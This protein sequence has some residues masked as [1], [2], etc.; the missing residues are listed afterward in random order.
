MVA[1]FM[2]VLMVEPV[3]DTR[4]PHPNHS[5]NP[6]AQAMQDIESQLQR[7]SMGQQGGQ[8]GGSVQQG[9]PHGAVGHSHAASMSQQGGVP[10][11]GGGT[12]PVNVGSGHPY[13]RTQSS[14]GQQQMPN[15]QQMRNM[16]NA[17][18]QQQYPGRQHS[19]PMPEIGITDI[20]L[21]S[22]QQYMTQP[23]Y[24]TMG[25]GSQNIRHGQ[26]SP[27]MRA[28]T[29]QMEPWGYPAY[30]MQ[31]L[32]SRDTRPHT[33]RRSTVVGHTPR[34]Y[35]DDSDSDSDYDEFGAIRRPKPT[36]RSSLPNTY[37]P[38]MVEFPMGVRSMVGNPAMTVGAP[39]A[40]PIAAY[41][42]QPQLVQR[43][44][45]VVPADRFERPY[46]V[47]SGYIMGHSLA[48]PTLSQDISALRSILQPMNVRFKDLAP[49]IPRALIN[50]LVHK[51]AYEIDALRHGYREFT[52][53]DL[54]ILMKTRLA[55]SDVHITYGFMGLVLGL[56]NFDIWLATHENVCR[57]HT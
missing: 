25:N 32:Q 41:P 15:Q 55:G 47:S 34:V 5:T 20:Q 48:Y 9:Y 14:V 31:S 40:G 7:M 54:G 27:Q 46:R 12:I 11:L 19:I 39:M 30:N 10:S 22:Q 29:V 24:Q 17:G 44:A 6:Q 50:I 21:G 45:A 2:A 1:L 26:M 35:L 36:H 49:E 28:A 3:K 43:G 33:H 53:Q 16:S 37:P 52:G 42:H 13:G 51:S 18:M 57:L 38:P 56:A 4:I 8:N 23:G